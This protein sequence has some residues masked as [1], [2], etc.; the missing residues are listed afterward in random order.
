MCRLCR[1]ELFTPDEKA[2][3]HVMNRTVR[4]CFLF[5]DDELTGRNYD[6]RKDWIELRMEYL[7]RYFGIDILCYSILSNH[8]HQVLRQRPDVVQQWSDTEVARRWLMLCPKRK[9]KDGSAKEPTEGQLNAIRNNPKKLAE[10]RSRL[11]DISWWMRLLCQNI[12]QRI[13]RDDD[14]KGKV[15]Q[16]RYKAVRLLDETSLLAC[17]AYVDLNPIR[18]AIAEV[19]EQSDYTSIQ[20]RIQA[21]KEE[22]EAELLGGG[23]PH[24]NV[25][26]AIVS[27]LAS[28]GKHD[29]TELRLK[30]R[31]K[32]IVPV[33]LDEL[34]DA[35]QVKP[36]QSGYRCSD[37]GFLNMSDGDYIEL[38]DW[39]ARVIVTGK[40]GST[41]PD[42]PPIF[43]RLNLGI[44]PESWCEL[45]TSFGTLFSTV[46]G[47]PH[48]VER[49]RSSKRQQRFT[50]KPEAR[51]LLTI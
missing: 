47:K 5:G 50:L 35:L 1:W 40:R 11:S 2:I 13:N 6:Y 46:A 9:N 31:D 22:V 34:R 37:L 19:L 29:W 36:S 26:Q 43:E 30:A 38:L 16:N 18:A 21:L 39:T 3:V 45:I 14:E 20:R 42:A 8:F 28:D 4:R 10:T 17:A 44:S 48:I 32:S 15:W 33:K 41:P 23:E 49:Y 51:L 24:S 12:A 27:S 25:S 7:A